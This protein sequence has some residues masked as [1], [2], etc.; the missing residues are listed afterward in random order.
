MKMEDVTKGQWIM[1]CV[2][3]EKM[4]AARSARGERAWKVESGQS[5]DDGRQ[6]STFIVWPSFNQFFPSEI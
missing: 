3:C 2:L 5:D 6:H 1:C 4:F